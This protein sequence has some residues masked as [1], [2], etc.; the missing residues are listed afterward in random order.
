MAI[1]FNTE[2]LNKN[3][4]QAKEEPKQDDLEFNPILE[5][6]NKIEQLLA[7]QDIPITTLKSSCRS[8]MLCIQNTPESMLQLEPKD[9]NKIIQAYKKIAGEELTSIINKQTKSKSRTVTTPQVKEVF[10]IM[11]ENATDDDLDLDFL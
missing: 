5:Q 2:Y 8:V 4:T 7:K 10:A 1:K 3:L 11:K 6:I 9:I